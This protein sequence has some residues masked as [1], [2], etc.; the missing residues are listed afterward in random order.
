MPITLSD[1]L[2]K[3]EEIVDILTA[4]QGVFGVFAAVIK[5]VIKSMTQR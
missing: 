3:V 4:D 2:G 5:E 1:V